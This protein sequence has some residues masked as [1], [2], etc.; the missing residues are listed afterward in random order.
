MHR[1]SEPEGVQT[2]EFVAGW[3]ENGPGTP[4]MMMSEVLG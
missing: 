4:E 1:S 2:P 3:S